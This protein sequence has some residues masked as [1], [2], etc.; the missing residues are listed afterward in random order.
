MSSRF[1]KYL[2]VFFPG[3]LVS[4]RWFRTSISKYVIL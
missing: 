3:I 4:N 1:I 2:G